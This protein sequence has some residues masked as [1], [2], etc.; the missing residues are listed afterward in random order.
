MIEGTADFYFGI[1]GMDLFLSI[2]FFC[3]MKICAKKKL[4]HLAIFLLNNRSFLST[5]KLNSSCVTI[6]FIPFYL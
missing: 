4:K 6:I 3:E 1:I 5:M 2:F